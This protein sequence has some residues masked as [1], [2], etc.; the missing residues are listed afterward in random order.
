[1][2]SFRLERSMPSSLLASSTVRLCTHISVS[3]L[4]VFIERVSFF[5]VDFHKLNMTL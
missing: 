4:S 3:A 5:N 1:M 2:T